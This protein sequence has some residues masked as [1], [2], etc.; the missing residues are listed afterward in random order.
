MQPAEP[1]HVSVAVEHHVAAGITQDQAARLVQRVRRGQVARREC[2]K[3]RSEPDAPRDL[4]S[5]GTQ[6]RHE[7]RGEGKITEVL[8]DGRRVVTFDGHTSVVG[9]THQGETHR[10]DSHSLHKVFTPQI[11][12]LRQRTLDINWLGLATIGRVEA[13]PKKNEEPPKSDRKGSRSNRGSTPTAGPMLT[14]GRSFDVVPGDEGGDAALVAP[15]EQTAVPR[16]GRGS[17]TRETTSGTRKRALVDGDVVQLVIDGVTGRVDKVKASVSRGSHGRLGGGKKTGGKARRFERPVAVVVGAP[18][19]GKDGETLVGVRLNG[20]GRTLYYKEAQCKKLPGLSR[21]GVS[22][23]CLRAFCDAHAG[24]LRGLSCDAVWQHIIHA[25]ADR[26]RCSLAAAIGHATY[27]TRPHARPAGSAP[28]APA[29]FVGAVNVYVSYAGESSFLSLVAAL[30]EFEAAQQQGRAAAQGEPPADTMSAAQ[31]EPPADTAAQ[32]E[33]SFFWFNPFCSDPTEEPHQMMPP[34]W[35]THVL[36]RDIGAIGRTCLVLVKWAA[37]TALRRA[38]VLLELLSSAASG[39]AVSVAMAADEAASF[40]HALQHDKQAVEDA[41][42]NWTLDAKIAVSS[43]AAQRDAV[44]LMLQDSAQRE[45]FSELDALISEQLRAWAFTTGKAALA[46]LPPEER[47]TSTLQMQLATAALAA[48]VTSV[49]EPLL[50]EAAAACHASFGP[51][52]PHTLRTDDRRAKMMWA[53]GRLAEAETLFGDVLRRRTEAHRGDENNEPTASTMEELALTYQ[54]GRKLGAALPLFRSALA[55]RARLADGDSFA[56]AHQ[57][58]ANDARLQTTKSN[59]G[60]LLRELGDATFGEAEPLLRSSLQ[61]KRALLGGKHPE[62]LIGLNQLAQL[63]NC[64]R[65]PRQAEALFREAVNGRTEVLGSR[66]PQTLNAMGHLALCL[67]E[68]GQPSAAVAALGDAVQI[69]TEVLGRQHRVTTALQAKSDRIDAALREQQGR[70]TKGGDNDDFDDDEASTS[71][72]DGTDSER[73]VDDVRRAAAAA[74]AAARQQ[75]ELS[76]RA[77]EVL[78][79]ILTHTKEELLTIF[80]AADKDNTSSVDA[81]EFASSLRAMGI[82][83]LTPRA[84]GEAGFDDGGVAVLRE[85]MGVFG[86][87]E[88]HERRDVF[89]LLRV[90]REERRRHRVRLAQVRADDEAAAKKRRKSPRGRLKQLWGLLTKQIWNT[91]TLPHYDYEQIEH[92]PRLDDK[93]KAT[94]RPS[95]LDETTS[96]AAKQAMNDEATAKAMFAEME[97]LAVEPATGHHDF[98][99]G[100]LMSKLGLHGLEKSLTSAA[101]TQGKGAGKMMSEAREVFLQKRQ[102]TQGTAASPVEVFLRAK[103]HWIRSRA[104]SR[105]AALEEDAAELRKLSRAYELVAAGLPKEQRTYGEAEAML[106]FNELI[107]SVYDGLRAA[108]IRFRY[109]AQTPV[110][111]MEAKSLFGGKKK[112]KKK[113][114]KKG[115]EGEEGEEGDEKEETAPLPFWERNR[116]SMGAFKRVDLGAKWGIVVLLCGASVRAS[117]LIFLGSATDDESGLTPIDFRLECERAWQAVADGNSNSSF[118]VTAALDGLQ[119][120]LERCADSQFLRTYTAIALLPASIFF[121]FFTF[122]CPYLIFYLNTSSDAVLTV[123]KTVGVLIIICQSFARF[124]LVM[125]IPSDPVGIEMA[126]SDN[127]LRLLAGQV[128]DAVFLFVGQLIFICMDTLIVKA[129][130]MRVVL[131]LTLALNLM[132]GLSQRSQYEFPSESG[133]LVPESINSW[134]KYAGATPKQSYISTFDFSVLSLL[135]T[136]ILTTVKWPHKLA[137]I[138]IQSDLYGLRAQKELERRAKRAKQQYRRIHNIAVHERQMTKDLGTIELTG[139]VLAAPQRGGGVTLGGL[140]EPSQ[141]HSALDAANERSAVYVRSAMKV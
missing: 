127:G 113:K 36:S 140:A 133:P 139:G 64:M 94:R 42:A 56:T 51:S 73:T 74:A 90:A 106:H 8:D 60:C 53:T 31:G 41:V 7:L 43:L 57:Q 12:E 21:L 100:A 119:L 62:T 29:P 131:G 77:A 37:P 95:E 44:A 45:R 112:K 38:W 122:F 91:L 114:G 63:M 130:R 132:E 14:S 134:L 65:R 97:K 10:Y 82:R 105:I 6:V 34:L 123:F 99:D 104:T 59:L 71:V 66:H 46:Q 39:A 116:P 23:A 126:Q 137:F 52:D 26:C 103:E 68:Q 69:S 96:A 16:R 141:A 61:A 83:L 115:E 110:D 1:T 107:M 20:K 11:D 3:R 15:A 24:L 50:D 111:S 22:A 48:G 55:V 88:E 125:L 67:C 129:P 76:E 136:G 121:V 92:R 35:V 49:A 87:D 33:R 19:V 28:V 9:T 128:L 118:N 108:S 102:H 120:S 17:L 86:Y 72:V 138:R 58:R 84:D 93:P 18:S 109:F 117:K 13:T 4:L 47:A 70:S 40:V 124:V 89:E 25:L 81:I 78:M 32:G 27:D 85:L 54:A 2:A 79:R 135:A 5:V 75:H 98:D 101:V 80:C 30:E